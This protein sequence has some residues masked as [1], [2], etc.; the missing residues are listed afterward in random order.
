[1]RDE[2]ITPHV[3]AS[4]ARLGERNRALIDRKVPRAVRW[5]FYHFA[6]VEGTHVHA[7]LRA[8]QLEYLHLALRK[9]I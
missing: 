1:V 6:G 8:R 7:Q 3:L 4:M 2:V 9:P 5:W